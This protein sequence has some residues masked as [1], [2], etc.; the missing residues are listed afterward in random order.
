MRVHKNGKNPRSLLMIRRKAFWLNR[1]EQQLF[2]ISRINIFCLSIHYCCF[3]RKRT[4]MQR[5]VGWFYVGRGEND[6]STYESFL[7]SPF[8]TEIVQNTS[9]EMGENGKEYYTDWEYFCGYKFWLF[10]R[11]SHLLSFVLSYLLMEI[12]ETSERIMI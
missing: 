3:W 2:L 9:L 11:L 5:N 10:A 4:D 12:T 1:A 8:T 7:L 6:L